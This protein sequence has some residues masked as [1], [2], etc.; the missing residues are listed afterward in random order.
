M[1]QEQALKQVGSVYRAAGQGFEIA[2]FFRLPFRV[3]L[4]I[5]FQGHA[6]IFLAEG[7]QVSLKLTKQSDGGCG[8]ETWTKPCS[9]EPLLLSRGFHPERIP[10]VIAHINLGHKIAFKDKNGIPSILWHDPKV[11]DMIVRPTHCP[12]CAG[13]LRP[14]QQH[15]RQQKCPHCGI[16]IALK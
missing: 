2:R 6:S 5:M 4:Y 8:L 13:Q 14:W 1:S 16:V 15:D 12:K 7:R 9:L 3:R 11:D 10:E